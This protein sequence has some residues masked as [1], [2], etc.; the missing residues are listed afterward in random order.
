[1]AQ[2]TSHAVMQQRR[3]ALEK[4]ITRH[5]AISLGLKWYFTGEPCPRGHVAKR[6]VS[7]R[8]C[9]QCVNERAK[10][11]RAEGAYVELDRRRYARD[12]EGVNGDQLLLASMVYALA[13]VR[14]DVDV[15]PSL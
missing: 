11:R 12:V 3:E 6:T 13:R 1:M 15:D 4:P 5:E 2:N 9:R 10:A 14:V 8:E 7:N